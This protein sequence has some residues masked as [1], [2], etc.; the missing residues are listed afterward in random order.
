MRQY[1]SACVLIWF[2]LTSTC[3]AG[4]QKLFRLRGQ[5][6]DADSRQPLA[7]RLYLQ[8]EDGSWF[9]PKSES[10]LGSAIPYQR[11]VANQ[12]KSLE[13]HTTL[14]A[15]PFVT[16]LPPGQYAVTI[17]RGKEY[18]PFSE[19]IRIGEPGPNQKLGTCTSSGMRTAGRNGGGLTSD[20]KTT[21]PF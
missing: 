17:E 14:S 16:D 18:F 9:F 3:A 8:A 13:M 4:D 7:C 11:K 5:V 6:V 15:H 2:T 10:P 21:M 20:S 19:Q 12:P 1:S